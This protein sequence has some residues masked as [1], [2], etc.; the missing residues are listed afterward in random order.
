MFLGIWLALNVGVIFATELFVLITTYAGPDRQQAWDNGDLGAAGRC[1][2]VGLSIPLQLTRTN[3]VNNHNTA[4]KKGRTRPV[5]VSG[6]GRVA[7]LGD[8]LGSRKLGR[9]TAIALDFQRKEGF[10]CQKGAVLVSL[11]RRRGGHVEG[12]VPTYGE[13]ERKR[14][15]R[16]R[17]VVVA[18]DLWLPW[19]FASSSQI[20]SHHAHSY[21]LERLEPFT[22][23]SPKNHNDSKTALF[24]AK[25]PISLSHSL[26][27]NKH[28][29]SLSD[30]YLENG[31]DLTDLQRVD[32]F[33]ACFVHEDSLEDT[34]ES[35]HSLP[36]RASSIPRVIELPNH[37][38]EKVKAPSPFS[39]PKGAKLRNATSKIP[40]LLETELDYT[41]EN[42]S[43]TK[44][45][46]S[47][48][49]RPIAAYKQGDLFLEF[50]LMTC[51]VRG[52]DD[53]GEERVQ[54]FQKR[55]DLADTPDIFQRPQYQ[56]SMEDEVKEEKS[57]QVA[58]L[59]PPKPTTPPKSP[60]TPMSSLALAA[61]AIQSS[62][63]KSPTK[64]P[65]RQGR[66]R[67]GFRCT[68]RDCG[69]EHPRKCRFGLLC[70]KPDCPLR[71]V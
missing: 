22:L 51:I 55:V 13:R 7:Y 45:D 23:S 70:R 57:I 33:F 24:L 56:T 48:S 16:E 63:I 53:F 26:V 64:M 3:V 44:L 6:H 52:Y 9:M 61:S 60:Q 54:R 58:T 71:H 40:M 5:G 66:C 11:G 34:D 30:F 35:G 8:G 31:L 29:M 37:G 18:V 12:M 59:S 1:I 39:I 49:G 69:F 67:Y 38:E 10:S 41:A 14:R 43:W 50:D 68:R 25:A 4:W 36:R 42:A 28:S 20:R 27:I 19:R 32:E 21:P 17:V 15:H 47:R 65:S 62:P 2:N 46:T